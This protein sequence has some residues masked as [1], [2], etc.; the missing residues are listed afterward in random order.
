MDIKQFEKQ[1]NSYVEEIYNQVREVLEDKFF[2]T[3]DIKEFIDDRKEDIFNGI[4]DSLVEQLDFNDK[5]PFEDIY[6]KIQQI[7]DKTINNIISFSG[8]E[9]SKV[10]EDSNKEERS[11]SNTRFDYIQNNV[12]LIKILNSNMQLF[13]SKLSK[14]DNLGD[15]SNENNSIEFQK[16]EIDVNSMGEEINFKPKLG[17]ISLAPIKVIETIKINRSSIIKKLSSQNKL[18]A[19]KLEFLEA[20]GKGLNDIA[21]KNNEALAKQQ[22]TFMK[23]FK[24][25]KN[26]KKDGFD[27]AGW[28]TGF[29]QVRMKLKIAKYVKDFLGKFKLFK[30]FFGWIDRM[31]RIFNIGLRRN[32]IT[33]PIM[34]FLDAIKNFKSGISS[35]IK[36]VITNMKSVQFIL[37]KW[38]SLLHFKDRAISLIKK[39]FGFIVKKIAG[40][41][42]KLSSKLL[43]KGL[44]KIITKFFGRF[45]KSLKPIPMLGGVVSAW[46]AYDRWKRGDYIGSA[47]EAIAAVIKFVPVVGTAIGWAID[48]GLLALDVKGTTTTEIFSRLGGKYFGPVIKD[49][50][51]GDYFKAFKKMAALYWKAHTAPLL[52]I[53]DQVVDYFSS[54]GSKS[55]EGAKKVWEFSKKMWDKWSHLVLDVR[56]KA[57]E[58]GKKVAKK[59]GEMKDAAVNW[60]GGL[61]DK[62]KSFVKENFDRVYMFLEKIPKY[63]EKIKNFKDKI[64]GQVQNYVDDKINVVKT[65]YDAV[66]EA[67]DDVGKDIKYIIESADIQFEN[68]AEQ[69][70]L[71]NNK[72]QI[73]S[74]TVIN[75]NLKLMR[76]DT[77]LNQINTEKLRENEAIQQEY[78]Y[79]IS[80][81]EQ[82]SYNETENIQEEKLPVPEDFKT[83]MEE[84]KIQLKYLTKMINSSN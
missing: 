59:I 37:R 55:V 18:I 13:Q 2:S 65:Y 3:E 10:V 41:G 79:F 27:I 78:D 58:F 12:K 15:E 29:L 34:K 6:K 47:L 7:N 77:L 74:K 76:S 16:D 1:I 45:A 35:G 42:A 54:V 82:S 19:K 4:F 39:P 28:V 56:D 44:I 26:I 23:M 83:K 22:Q 20:T 62:A 5:N 73:Q 36:K 46:F 31:K 61:V 52:W 14:L 49:I 53:K 72:E 68:R 38:Q 75:E 33:K 50:A 9:L 48:L 64:K 63:I 80:N 21:K 69:N 24:E 40:L 30:K 8:K 43:G 32:P 57:I 81:P 84:L 51:N 17:S 25:L 66:I 60:L 11:F 70:E 67:L 71:A